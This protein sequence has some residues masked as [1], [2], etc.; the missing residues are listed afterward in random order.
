MTD[1]SMS[2]P[3]AADVLGV[4]RATMGVWRKKGMGP[5]YELAPPDS[6]HFHSTVFLYRLSALLDFLASRGASKTKLA[7][8]ELHFHTTRRQKLAREADKA[9][10]AAMSAIRAAHTARA[11]AADVGHR[12]SIEIVAAGKF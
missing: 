5:A 3:N 7:A 10:M 1:F 12:P 11:A 4:G 6:E 8:V 2:T 9:R